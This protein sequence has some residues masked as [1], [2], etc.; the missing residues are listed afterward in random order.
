MADTSSN[1]LTPALATDHFPSST[2]TPIHTLPL[3]LLCLIFREVVRSVTSQDDPAVTGSQS[4]SPDEDEIVQYPELLLRVCTTW[5]NTAA[6]PRLWTFIAPSG[7][8]QLGPYHRLASYV[9]NR[10]SKSADCGL[11]VRIYVGDSDLNVSRKAFEELVGPDG[12]VALRW[13]S[14][15]VDDVRPKVLPF[16]SYAMPRLRV[17]NIDGASIGGTNPVSI[18][19]FSYLPSLTTIRYYEAEI[20]HFNRTIREQIT[21]LDISDSPSALVRRLGHFPNITHLTIYATSYTTF[22]DTSPIL[23]SSLKE[24][25]IMEESDFAV[26]NDLQL[27][28]IDTL[29]VH[30]RN[31]AATMGNKVPLSTLTRPFPSLRKLTLFN[32][33]FLGF[34]DEMKGFLLSFPNLRT[35]ALPGMT[36]VH[37]Q[38]VDLFECMDDVGVLPEL[39]HCD[40]DE[41]NLGDLWVNARIQGMS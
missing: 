39:Q 36:W 12:A 13:E 19:V 26:L 3:E 23:L 7:R 4:H 5:Y 30:P 27:P 34:A 41:E 32:I 11:T 10:V 37:G 20:I 29:V 25:V 2:S 9:R 6:D 31:T 8:L 1:V 14:L 38:L 15:M 24:I 33:D 22:E 28:A 21:S 35:F 40:V 18:G 17:L 16:L